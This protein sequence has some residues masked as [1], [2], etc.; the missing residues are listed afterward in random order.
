LISYIDIC[1][2]LTY[3]L[4]ALDFS[5]QAVK[6]IITKDIHDQWENKWVKLSSKLHEIKRTTYLWPFPE[7]TSRKQK[8]AITCLRIGHT[9][10]A[11]QNLMKREDPQFAPFVVRLSPSNPSSQTAGALTRTEEKLTCQTSQSL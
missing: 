11:H 8:T 7:N 3:S 9:H 10:I 5:Y 2:Y 4:T 1:N 6:R